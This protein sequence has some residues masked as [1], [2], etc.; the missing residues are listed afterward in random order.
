MAE[1]KIKL[2]K[3]T[4]D[5]AEIRAS[6]YVIFDTEIKGFGLRVF[7][8]GQ[9]SWIF[10]YKVD[11]G[12]RTAST[13]RVTIGRADEFTPDEARKLADRLRAQAKVGQDPQA[14]KVAYRKAATVSDLIDVFLVHVASKKRSSTESL[15]R[16]ILE[17][18]VK[19][20]VG[21]R[22]AGDVKRT[23]LAKL[24]LD[25][26]DTPY[27]ANRM[28]AVVGSMYS[29]GGKHGLVPEGFNPARGIEKFDESV[30]ERLLSAEELV[31]LG[32]AIRVAETEGV[33]WKIDPKKK[34]KHVPKEKREAVIG[35]HAAAALRLLIFTGARP[36][37]QRRQGCAGAFKA[38]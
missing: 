30:R 16:D 10:E 29:F 36:R 27:Q 8:S 9:K 33:P 15:Y 21:S 35:A 37:I 4:V 38:M 2:T 25:L 22:K 23:E 19:P 7:P 17:R 3:R 12:G 32:D 31:R 11:G 26:A 1:R 20:V 6:R 28:L 34:T 13:K 24:H 18:L 14:E 5:A